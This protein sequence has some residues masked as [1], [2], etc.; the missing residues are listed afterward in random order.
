MRV[1]KVPKRRWTEERVTR[2][3]EEGRQKRGD[4]KKEMN[5]QNVSN[6][7]RVERREVKGRKRSVGMIKRE[8]DV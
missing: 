7:S 5:Q 6:K 8:R 1:K 4:K 2:K 3:K